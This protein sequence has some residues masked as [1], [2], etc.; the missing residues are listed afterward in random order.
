[1]SSLMTA[2]TRSLAGEDWITAP[3]GLLLPPGTP[4]RRHRP[5]G[6]G[7][8]AGAGGFDLGFTMAG[9]HMTG[10]VE[11]DAYAAATYLTN[12]GG[13]G[14]VVHGP[15]GV[16][17]PAVADPGDH[18]GTGWISARHDGDIAPDK[19]SCA[20]CVDARPCDHFWLAD[21]RNVSGAEILDAL[22]LE[23]GEL[24]AVIGGPPC[25]GFSVAGKRDVMDP[26][27]SLVFEFARLIREIRPK[28]FVMENVTGIVDMI[29]P[30]GIPVIDAL[31]R[32]LSDA[33][34]GDYNTLR[35]GLLAQAGAGVGT[36]YQ[37]ARKKRATKSGE[38]DQL[39][40]WGGASGTPNQGGA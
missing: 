33:D 21:I 2:S 3:S 24:D 27:N 37:P 25:Q 28:T 7:L 22:G 12:L 31:S 40:L 6:L 19:C 13:P 26:R 32:Q 38:R 15:D 14:T 35:K 8:F 29:T 10:A 23:V 20:F 17:S 9:W 34:Y 18:F 11:F 4:E 16:M 1:M 36:P 30:E 5:I 39:D